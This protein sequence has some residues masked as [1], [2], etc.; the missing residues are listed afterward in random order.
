MAKI[1]S[2]TMNEPKGPFQLDLKESKIS[3]LLKERL[4]GAT[5]GCVGLKGN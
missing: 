5:G 3:L 2:S 1:V 4:H